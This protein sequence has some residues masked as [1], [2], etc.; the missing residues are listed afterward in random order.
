MTS[1]LTLTETKV[2]R[3]IAAGLTTRQIAAELHMMP[4]TART[5]AQNI[6]AKLHAHTRAQAVSVAMREGF[7]W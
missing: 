2:L 4:N 3:L 6:N 5:H 1:R 7:I